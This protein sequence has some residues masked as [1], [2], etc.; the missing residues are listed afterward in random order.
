M[1]RKTG[2]QENIINYYFLIFEKF[3]FLKNMFPDIHTLCDNLGIKG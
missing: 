1:A 2:K 3:Q